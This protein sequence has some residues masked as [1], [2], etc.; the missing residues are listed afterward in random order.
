MTIEAVAPAA[1]HVKAHEDAVEG[2]R[3][4]AEAKAMKLNALNT[5]KMQE[6]AAGG[7]VVT[8]TQAPITQNTEEKRAD[9]T[10]PC[11][12]ATHWPT[13]AVAVAVLAA[14]SAAFLIGARVGARAQR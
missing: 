5:I 11:H 12:E 1:I 9:G 8:H 2:K 6:A 10:S 14:V 4:A 7:G 3:R 13:A